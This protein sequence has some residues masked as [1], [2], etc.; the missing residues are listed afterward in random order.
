MNDNEGR[1]VNTACERNEILT[2]WG[3]QVY[4]SIEVFDPCDPNLCHNGLPCDMVEA[5][6]DGGPV[7]IS[8]FGCLG[9]DGVGLP[10]E[11]VVSRAFMS[12][13]AP[14]SGCAKIGFTFVAGEDFDDEVELILLAANVCDALFFFELDTALKLGRDRYILSNCRGYKE[15]TNSRGLCN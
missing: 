7:A 6:I 2:L 14:S 3:D 1:V 12:F 9:N 4:G 10:L 13:A 11:D 8:T 5:T 15:K